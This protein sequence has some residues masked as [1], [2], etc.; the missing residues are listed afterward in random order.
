MGCCS[1]TNAGEAQDKVPTLRVGP[2]GSASVSSGTHKRSLKS[3]GSSS[4]ETSMAGGGEECDLY[5]APREKT[6][7]T[8][9]W[10]R[11]RVIGS[12]SV[13]L[14]DKWADK[15][16]RGL[17]PVHKL[18]KGAQ[19]E[20]WLLRTSEGRQAVDKLV[21]V[22]RMATE[23][24]ERST[25]G[26]TIPDQELRE[27]A[28]KEVAL[29]HRLNHRHVIHLYDAWI[30]HDLTTLHLV[31]EYCGGGTLETVIADARKRRSAAADAAA[32]FAD[33]DAEPPAAAESPATTATATAEEEE[34]EEA[35][36]SLPRVRGYLSQLF[37]AVA[38]VHAHKVIH[39]DI[40]PA[41]LFLSGDGATVKLGDFGESTALSVV[42]QPE[43]SISDGG[44]NGHARA[45]SSPTG[46]IAASRGKKQA[47]KTGGRRMSCAGTPLY[48]APEVI[49]VGADSGGGAPDAAGASSEKPAYGYA[50]DVFSLGCVSYELLA[51][52]PPFVAARLPLLLEMIQERRRTGDPLPDDTPSELR[53]M[54]D[55]MLLPRPRDRPTAREL[56]ARL[57]DEDGERAT[58]TEVEGAAVGAPAGASTATFSASGSE[59][60]RL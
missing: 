16:F 53:G 12:E 21:Q 55:A 57:V 28:E 15:A 40:K 30:E 38:H 4:V 11:E 44:G 33:A 20:V 60:V 26:A 29:L 59:E 41:N 23:D 34:E 51:L 56:R 18:G 9:A 25:I 13:Q 3:L 1:S 46:R 45:A 52:S 31:M 36:L 32:A 58:A 19:G 47:K 6:P 37:R 35:L 2:E 54:I 48:M 42:V 49:A 8:E 50:A 7:S 14:A 27:R 39:R 24:D 22:D 10:E 5:G 43:R 17:K